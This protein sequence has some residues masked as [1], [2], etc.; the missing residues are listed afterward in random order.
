MKFKVGDF[1]IY[2]KWKSSTHPSLRAKAIHPAQHG[3]TYSYAIEKFWKVVRVCDDTIEVETRRGK[4]R[5]L[6]QHDDALRK[7][8]LIDRLFFKDRFF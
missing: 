7:T 2:Q 4:R 8:G 6:D 3:E 1:V 5:V